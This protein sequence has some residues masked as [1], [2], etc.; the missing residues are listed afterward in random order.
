MWERGHRCHPGC[1]E[2]LFEEVRLTLS[3]TAWGRGKSLWKGP[4]WVGLGQQGKERGHQR[5]APKPL[6]PPTS[7]PPPA[8]VWDLPAEVLVRGSMPR[9][10]PS[11]MGHSLL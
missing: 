3:A 8:G 7:F 1:Q 4:M 9:G 6:S 5:P 11:P 2:S 10:S